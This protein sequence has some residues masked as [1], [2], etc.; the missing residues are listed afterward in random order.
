[1]LEAGVFWQMHDFGFD[2][3]GQAQRDDYGGRGCR[4]AASKKTMKSPLAWLLLVLWTSIMA[5]AQSSYPTSPVTA[6][7][8]AV[9]ARPDLAQL[10]QALAALQQVAEATNADLAKLR[11]ERWRTSSDNKNQSQADTDS[12]MKNLSAALPEMIAGARTNPG[13]VAPV[14]KLY[15]D[16]NVVYD[17]LGGL[18]ESAGAFGPKGQYADLVADGHAMDRA[19]HSLAEYVENLAA[20]KDA[21]LLRLETQAELAQRAAAMQKTVISDDKPTSAKRPKKK[22]KTAKKKPTSTTAPPPPN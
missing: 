11:I 15:R 19:R 17:V 4:L 18:T 16:V 6:P 22:S 9:A 1:M 21:E 13:A 2:K 10:S 5:P 14:F 3:N 20:A 8:R 12:L 7:T